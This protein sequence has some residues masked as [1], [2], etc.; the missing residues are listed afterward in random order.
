MFGVALYGLPNVFEAARQLSRGEI[1]LPMLYATGMAFMLWSGMP[2]SSTVMAMFHAELATPG[3]KARARLRS[4]A[5][6]EFPSALR[7]ARLRESD[8]VETRIDIDRL[9]VGHIIHLRP[10]DY[11]PVDG[12]VAEGFGA[13][14]E[15]MLTGVMGAIDKAPGDRV[16]ASTY[17]R[18]GSF[19][20]R[21]LREPE[22]RQRAPSRPACRSA[23][24]LPAVERG[25]RARRES[26]RQAG[27]SGRGAEPHRDAHAENFAGAHSS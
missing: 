2:F 21:V 6:W 7:L 20:V 17:L 10:G 22:R 25:S 24:L 4:R 14:D 5:F 18:T 23:H 8:G 13:V 1:G 19:A 3:A 16:Y 11:I 26:Q 9:T 27:A 12:V 15:D